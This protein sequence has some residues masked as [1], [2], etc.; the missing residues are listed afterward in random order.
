MKGHFVSCREDELEA[1]IT[2]DPVSSPAWALPCLLFFSLLAVGSDVSS[3]TM[4]AF[5]MSDTSGLT[6]GGRKRQLILH[7][8]CLSHKKNLIFLD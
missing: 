7:L 4:F 8:R 2:P 5:E 3:L 1:H 6:W